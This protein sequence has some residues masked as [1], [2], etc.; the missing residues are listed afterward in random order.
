MPTV[1]FDSVW[2]LPVENTW[3]DFTFLAY[4]D[5]GQLI[6]HDVGLQYAGGKGTVY[7][8]GIWRVSIGKQGRDDINDWV[9]V[10]YGQGQVAY[11]ADGSWLGW[12]G[13]LGGTRKIGA[14]VQRLAG[15]A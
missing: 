6:V 14:A 13:L 3:G 2:Y 11:F 4:R 15:R 1:T 10:E 9:K 5:K 8:Q 12:G 7:I